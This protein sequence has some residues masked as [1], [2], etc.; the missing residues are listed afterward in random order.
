[1][2]GKVQEPLQDGF[3]RILRITAIMTFG[4][5]V[6]T[7]M[8]VVVDF[9]Q[10]GPEYIATSV[11]GGGGTLTTALDGLFNKVFTVA[12]SAWQQGGIMNGNFG[13][14]LLAAA[15]ILFGLALIIYAAFLIL[16][17][18]VMTTI[19]L[20]LGPIFIVM[21]LFS[22]TQRYFESWL[23]AISNYAFLLILAVCVSDIAISLAESYMHAMAPTES[24]LKNMANLGDVVMLC[25]VFSLCVLIIHQVPTISA[26]LGGG[27]A[28]ATQGALGH[29]MNSLRPTTAALKLRR[30]TRDFR[31]TKKAATAPVVAAKNIQA[32]YQKRFSSNSVSGS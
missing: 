20:A 15:V 32:A 24:A 10:K 23:G 25:A 17:S 27:F 19:L 8:G 31:E 29:A 22:T 18:K 14:Y 3:F 16:L 28:L 6:G 11:V 13:L 1:M 4:L 12:Q 30:V 9:L 26:T 2:F 7:Y 21:L 5:T